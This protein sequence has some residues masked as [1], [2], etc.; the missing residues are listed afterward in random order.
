MSM[1]IFDCEQGSAEWHEC[2]RGIPTA[3]RFADVIAEGGDDRGLPQTVIDSM[4][5]NGCTAGQLAAAIKAAKSRSAGAT[6]RKY[7]R[8]LVAET[9]RGTVED[10]GYTNAHMERGKEQEDEARQLYAFLADVEPTR[11]GFIRNGR[12]GCSPDSLIG[13]DGGLEIKTAL[14]DIQI[15]RLQRGEL[16]TEHRAQVQGSMFVTGRK[17]WDFVSYSQGLRPMVVRVE[18][19]D[20]YIAKLAVAIDAFNTELDALVASLD[21]VQQFRRVA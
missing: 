12:A 6:K 11:V 10:G 4:V 1:E 14:G 18:R 13:E 17:W 3:S 9:I 16:P 19:D 21:G 20:E 15:E 7:M 8:V 5:K 2:R